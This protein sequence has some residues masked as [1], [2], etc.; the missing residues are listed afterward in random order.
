MSKMSELAME[1]DEYACGALGFESLGEALMNGY[2]VDYENHSLVKP[3]I[4][5]EQEKAHEA[6]LKEKRG[7]LRKLQLAKSTMRANGYH[8]CV[9]RIED[10]IKFIEEGEH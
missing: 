1:L 6:W 3:T 8:R 4:D 9:E 7:V 10:A 2:E 5:E